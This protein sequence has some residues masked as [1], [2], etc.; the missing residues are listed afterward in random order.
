MTFYS[1][2]ILPFK[3]LP[4][5][6]STYKYK[7]QFIKHVHCT[8]TKLGYTRD[9]NYTCQD[10][11]IHCIYKTFPYSTKLLKPY[12]TGTC[13]ILLNFFFTRTPRD[14]LDIIIPCKKKIVANYDDLKAM[15]KSFEWSTRTLFRVTVDS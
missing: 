4:C 5:I 7:Y 14:I 1:S 15:E 2:E 9:K 6:I 10:F 13:K 8:Y 12:Q 3:I 11:V